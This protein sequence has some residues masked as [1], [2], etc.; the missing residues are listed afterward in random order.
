MNSYTSWAFSSL[1]Y[2]AY[3]FATRAEILP[4]LS[5]EEL[6]RR[7]RQAGLQYDAMPHADTRPILVR[8]WDW[9][10]RIF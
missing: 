10:Q 9:M 8:L 6:D 1:K 4:F 5:P 3:M 7:F 2:P